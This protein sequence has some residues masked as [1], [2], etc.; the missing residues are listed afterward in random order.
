MYGAVGRGVL[1]VSGTVDLCNLLG[2]LCTSAVGSN[3]HGGPGLGRWNYPIP[4]CSGVQMQNP[5]ALGK[6]VCERVNVMGR[7]MHMRA[8]LDIQK[9]FNI[10]FEMY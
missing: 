7:H 6:H 2:G 1:T 5:R 9:S 10:E 3:W 4:I 8:D